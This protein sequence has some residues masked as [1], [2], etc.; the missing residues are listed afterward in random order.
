MGWIEIYDKNERKMNL[1]TLGL[2]GLKLSV[3]SPS[4]TVEKEAVE[5]MDG[6]IEVSRRLNPRTLT[7]HFWSK[8][9]DYRDSLEKRNALYGLL[10]NG[11]QYFVEESNNPGKRWKVKIGDW[12]PNRVNSR[13][14]EIEVPMTADAGV[15]ESVNLHEK[16]FSD[17]LFQ[18][19][20]EGSKEINMRK[21][22]VT[23]I[24]FRGPSTGL[25]LTNKTTGEVWKYTGSTTSNDVILIK[26]VRSFKNNISIFGQTNRKMLS[27]APGWNEIEVSGSTEFDLIIRTRFYYL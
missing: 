11:E 10:G 6:E 26:G 25:Q 18:F 7:G 8:S 14:Q 1:E 5:G 24:E 20:N 16:Y 13:I 19:H 27:F 23:E 12:D 9:S 2:L 22:A 21:Q 17:T 15:S 4:Y 3:P